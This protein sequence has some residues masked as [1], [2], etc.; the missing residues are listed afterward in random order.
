MANRPGQLCVLQRGKSLYT[1]QNFVD[2]FN[3]LVACMKNIKGSK[4]CQVEWPADDTPEITV[5]PPPPSGGTVN[6]VAEDDTNIT[7]TQEGDVTKVGV[8]YL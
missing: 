6:L 8:Y 1:Q 3:W 7:F 5:E 4:N 2:T